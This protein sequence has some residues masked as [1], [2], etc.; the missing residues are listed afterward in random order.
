[1]RGV[2]SNLF[3]VIETVPF[4]SRETDDEVNERKIAPYHPI[5]EHHFHLVTDPT[6]RGVTRL[7]KYNVSNR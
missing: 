4:G 1:L 2:I 5:P 3:V 6:G 7:G